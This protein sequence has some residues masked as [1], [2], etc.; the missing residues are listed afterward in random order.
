MGKSRMWL[1][2]E[3]RSLAN[4]WVGNEDEFTMRIPSTLEGLASLW[5]CI[6]RSWFLWIV[7]SCVKNTKHVPAQV[8]I[9][10]TQLMPERK[11]R[12]SISLHLPTSPASLLELSVCVVHVCVVTFCSPPLSLWRG[13]SPQD[14]Y[15]YWVS[16]AFSLTNEVIWDQHCVSFLKPALK[17]VW[18]AYG[19]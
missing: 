14:A 9:D 19:R 11:E 12:F 10:I 2:T 4:F 8:R 6:C 18:C 3:E 7:D 16:V 17:M 5:K 1:L 13:W 15:L